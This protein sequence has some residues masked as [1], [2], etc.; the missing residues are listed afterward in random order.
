MRKTEKP[1][2]YGCDGATVRRTIFGKLMHQ[3]EWKAYW[4]GNNR[5][6]LPFWDGTSGVPRSGWRCYHCGEFVWDQTDQA[7]AAAFA[8]AV[9]IVKLPKKPRYRV[10]AVCE[11]V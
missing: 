11:P 8:V 5:E 7:F 6:V 10:K 3:W 9:G 1:Y 4:N 2:L